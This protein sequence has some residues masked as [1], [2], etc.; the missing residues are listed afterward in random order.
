MAVESLTDWNQ[1]KIIG[2]RKKVLEHEFSRMNSRQR[3]AVFAVNGPLLVLAGAGSGKTTV[4]VNRI[5]N[6]VRFGDA[7]HSSEVKQEPDTGLLDE[8][9]R[10]LETGAPLPESECV[11]VKIN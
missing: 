11:M 5:A 3:E 8:I 2:L 6:I 7:Y 1:E 4:L 10:C 9:S